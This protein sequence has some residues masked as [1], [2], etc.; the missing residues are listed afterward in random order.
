MFVYEHFPNIV[1]VLN[2]F[3]EFLEDSFEKDLSGEYILNELGK[4]IP[5]HIQS[6]EGNAAIGL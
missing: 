4:D 5:R 2:I 6:I 1:P 3:A